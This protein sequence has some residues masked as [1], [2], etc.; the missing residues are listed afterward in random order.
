MENLQNL[1]MS[2]NLVDCLKSHGILLDMCHENEQLYVDSEWEILICVREKSRK[3]KTKTAGH[4]VN[5][6]FIRSNI[7]LLFILF[8]VFVRLI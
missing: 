8:I 2:G 1:E 6:W 3:N 4:S 5:F 7:L